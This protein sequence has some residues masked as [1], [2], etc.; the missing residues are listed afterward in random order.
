MDFSLFLVFSVWLKQ[1]VCERERERERS[2]SRF[3]KNV[4]NFDLLFKALKNQNSRLSFVRLVTMA[5]ESAVHQAQLPSSISATLSFVLS[6][7]RVLHKNV[8]N[9]IS[10]VFFCKVL[11][12]LLLSIMFLT[13]I[14]FSQKNW[15]FSQ[16]FSFFPLVSPKCLIIGLQIFPFSLKFDGF[17]CFGFFPSRRIQIFQKN[18]FYV[19]L[20][21]SEHPMLMT[22]LCVIFSSFNFFFLLSWNN[23]F[24]FKFLAGYQGEWKMVKQSRQQQ[25]TLCEHLEEHECQCYVHYEDQ[26]YEL[27]AW[28]PVLREERRMRN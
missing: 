7:Q 6:V 28:K 23:F 24:K 14:N 8:F 21:H 17:C 13:F 19:S 4:F 10:S 20:L 27:L 5:G 26:Q 1:S 2:F 16:N 18:L 15:L 22:C 11:K 25:L 3:F 9:F 12:S